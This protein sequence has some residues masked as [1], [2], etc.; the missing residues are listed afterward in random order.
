MALIKIETDKQYSDLDLNFTIHPIKKDINKHIDDMAVINSIK[1]LIMT[2]HYE[3]LFQPDIGSNIRKLLFEP[4]D[5][6][7][8]AA[9]EREIE[10][11][12]T[13]YEN[14]MVINTVSVGVDSDNNA[15]SV[16]LEFT[17]IN[18]SEPILIK[19]LL[20]RIR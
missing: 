20:E 12:L 13:N 8:A 17:I 2:N 16:T 3:R 14:R 1:N 6:I 7:T 11:T 5:N 19:F 4:L 18:R 10:Q 9:I 15:F